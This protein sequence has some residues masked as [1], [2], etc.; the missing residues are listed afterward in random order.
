MSELTRFAAPQRGE[1]R[2]GIPIEK[3]VVIT[4]DF[5]EKNVELLSKYFNHYMLYPDIWLETTKSKTC[6][7][8]L[9]Y[10]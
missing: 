10:Y 3:G 5:L 2:E 4:E 9:L 1:L 7:R 6:P 8:T